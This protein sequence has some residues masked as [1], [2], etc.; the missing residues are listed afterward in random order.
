M[1]VK[2]ISVGGEWTKMERKSTHLYTEAPRQEGKKAAPC[3][4]VHQ[5]VRGPCEINTHTTA[6]QE[7]TGKGRRRLVT[8]DTG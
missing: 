3:K 5:K 4:N 7:R 2:Y 8:E 1:P 6:D